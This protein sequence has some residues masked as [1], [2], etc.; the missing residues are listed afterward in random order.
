MPTVT[1]TGKPDTLTM[2]PV[3]AN[4]GAAASE[5]IQIEKVFVYRDDESAERSSAVVSVSPPFCAACAAIHR[6]EVKTISTVDKVLSMF[7]SIQILPAILSGFACLFFGRFILQELV[8]GE[9]VDGLIWCLPTAFFLAISIGCLAVARS[10]TRH[11]IAVP[12]TSI[13]SAFGFTDDISKT[14]EERHH[15]YSLGNTAFAS[16]FIA[17]NSTRIWSAQ[18]RAHASFKR[19]IMYIVFGILAGAA[20]IYGIYDDYFT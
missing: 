18:Q 1:L 15:E 13:S 10:S 9:F 16:A 6:R 19:R 7:R 2:P 3:C 5:R 8:K 11:H 4:C 20:V 17:A 12:P 14:F